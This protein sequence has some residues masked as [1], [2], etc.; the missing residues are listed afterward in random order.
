MPELPEVQ[1]T[2][3][4]LQ[5]RVLGRTFV[6]VWSDWQKT[7]TF[8]RK[9]AAFKKQLKGKKILRVWRRGKNVIFELSDGYSLLIHMKMTGHLLVEP[10]NTQDP[11]N[12]YLHIMFFLDD[13][14]KIALSD[15]RK[16]AKVE[17]RPTKELLQIFEGLGPEPLEKIFTFEKFEKLFVRKKGKVKEI[18]MRPSFIAGIGNIY[19][20]EALWWA[21]IHPAK[22]VSRLNA[23]ELKLLYGAI[24]KVLQLG[25]NFGGDS[26]SDY[27]DVDGNKGEFEGSKKVYQREGEKCFRCKSV[28]K[29]LVI[30]QRSSFYCPRCQ[31]L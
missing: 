25:I 7:V 14:R 10:W 23:R 31:R 22:D 8:P 19:A 16:F 29:R 30:A 5:K 12:G 4:G 9:F 17:L 24:K 20:S 3:N 11:M 15:L 18:I 13:G 26:F 1:T 21:K 6:R 27:R 28:I 2:V